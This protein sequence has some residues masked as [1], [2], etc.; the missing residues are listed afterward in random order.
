MAHR[1]H[2]PAV[3]Q[4]GAPTDESPSPG[5]DDDAAADDASKSE[6]SSGSSDDEDDKTPATKRM[7]KKVRLPPGRMIAIYVV[8]SLLGF[9]Y[10][11]MIVA[12]LFFRG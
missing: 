8:L 3:I 9:F 4:V 5:D 12:G 7:R 10:L 11:F 1:V 6:D 2:W